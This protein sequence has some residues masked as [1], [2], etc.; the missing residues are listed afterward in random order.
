M[1][2]RSRQTTVQCQAGSRE[3]SLAF[4]LPMRCTPYDAAY[5]F[6]FAGME[7]RTLRGGKAD[8]SISSPL[9][10]EASGRPIW[11]PCAPMRHLRHQ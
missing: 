4:A 2:K 10:A 9:P 3:P 7:S 8:L 1:P 5:S 6:A 11:P